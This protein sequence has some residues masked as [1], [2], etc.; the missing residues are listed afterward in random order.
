MNMRIAIPYNVVEAKGKLLGLDAYFWGK[1]SFKYR[2][3]LLVR[4]A[5]KLEGKPLGCTLEVTTSVEEQIRDLE[6]IA[7]Q[8]EVRV[9]D[10]E[11]RVPLS[12]LRLAS[13]IIPY[14][15][16]E[17]TWRDHVN[18]MVVDE[19]RMASHIASYILSLNPLEPVGVRWFNVSFKSGVTGDPMLDYLLKVDEGFVSSFE[20]VVKQCTGRA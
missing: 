4:V 17:I 12:L 14:R 7:E 16:A 19:L 11:R 15:V 9:D 1:L 6:E 5:S 8:R 10:R 13:M 3:V 2:R 18:S 20:S